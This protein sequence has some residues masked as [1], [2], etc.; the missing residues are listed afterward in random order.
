MSS[1]DTMDRATAVEATA[2]SFTKAEPS[3]MI[4]AFES[5]KAKTMF[6]TKYA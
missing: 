4:F 5:P 3:L 2:Y 1:V 6:M